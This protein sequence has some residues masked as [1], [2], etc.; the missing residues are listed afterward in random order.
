MVSTIEPVYGFPSEAAAQFPSCVQLTLCHYICNVGCLSCPVGRL[1]RGDSEARSLWEADGA[2]RQ[3]MSW[4]VFEKA[5][6]ETGQHPKAFMRFHARGEPTLHPRFVDM[7]DY[8]KTVGVT[9]VQVFTNGVSMDK[10]LAL[11]T[12][13]TRLDVIEFSV[14]GHSQTYQALMGN[15]HFEQVVGNV[16]RFVRL[17]DELDART[18]IVV[19]AVDQPGFQPDKETHRQFWTGRV[20]QVILRPYHSWGGRIPSQ[21]AAD[22]AQRRPCPQIWTRLT[23]GPTG[24][25]LFCFNSWDEKESEIAGDLMTPGAT[26]AGIWQSER[27]AQA[28]AAHLAGNYT[29]DCCATCTDWVGSSWGDNSYESLLRKFKNSSPA[30]G[31]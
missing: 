12:L 27:Y 16:L 24:N 18:K 28:R 30:L 14:H 7:I 17:R 19:S 31:C 4:E 10:S 13:Q 11:R 6:R 25:I 23:V 22:T 2:N 5:A 20:D 9:T 15:E 8:A 21:V 26:I 1:N 3:F 29:L